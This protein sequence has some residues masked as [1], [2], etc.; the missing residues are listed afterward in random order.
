MSL[1]EVKTEFS[2]RSFQRK[3]VSSSHRNVFRYVG[4]SGCSGAG[5]DLVL[6]LVVLVLFWYQC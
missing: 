4:G 2:F 6:A 1:Q 5:T 3:D